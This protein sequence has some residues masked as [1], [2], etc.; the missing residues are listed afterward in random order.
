MLAVIAYGSDG[1]G[2]HHFQERIRC[3]V[4]EDVGVDGQTYK[5][6]WALCHAGDGQQEL[7]TRSFQ[8]II[9]SCGRNSLLDL[10][11]EFRQGVVGNKALTVFN[12][13]IVSDPKVLNSKLLF[14]YLQWWDHQ[15]Q[16]ELDDEYLLF[17]LAFYFRVDGDKKQRAFKSKMKE[18][19]IANQLKTVDVD[20]LLPLSQIDESDLLQ[21]IDDHKLFIPPDKQ[22]NIA[23]HIIQKTNGEY[24]KAIAEL[25]LVVNDQYHKILEEMQPDDDNG[26]DDEW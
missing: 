10:S 22:E 4:H 8:Q 17:L 1:D 20:V 7:R 5:P 19:R 16:S 13:D 26:S 23:K 11:R 18:A 2:L 14:E 3:F 6:S 21:F 12:H 24:E 9:E 25:E 15:L